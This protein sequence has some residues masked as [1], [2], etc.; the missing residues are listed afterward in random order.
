MATWPAGLP[1]PSSDSLTCTVGENVL[2]RTA[3]SGRKETVRYGSAA[4]D[5]WSVDLKLQKTHPTYGDQTEIFSTFYKQDLNLGVN[6]FA[7]GWIT[8]EL[9]YSD[10]RGKIVSAPAIRVASRTIVV[11][12]FDIAIKKTSTCPAVDTVWGGGS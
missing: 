2:H 12:S 5:K 11:I 7:A 9:R 10:H 6:W 3:Q 4:P 1:T 8:N